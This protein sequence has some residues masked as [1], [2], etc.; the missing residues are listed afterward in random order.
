MTL[1]LPRH[2][3]GLEGPWHGAHAKGSEN[4]F[5]LARANA[6]CPR[7]TTQAPA[8]AARLGIA[9]SEQDHPL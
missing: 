7:A 2:G 6:T 9:N 3:A 8:F 5:F 4:P 1:H